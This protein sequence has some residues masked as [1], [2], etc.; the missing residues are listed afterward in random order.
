MEIVIVPDAEA[1]ARVVADRFERVVRGAGEQGATLGLATGSS[2]V[3][4]YAELIRRHR[5]EGLSFAAGR[6]FLLDEYVG[7]GPADAQSYHR[8]IR[9]HFTADVDIPDAAVL[10]PDGTA[11]DPSAEAAR[12]DAAIAA[13]GGIDLQVLGIGT[14]GHIAFNEPGSSLSSR[15]RHAALTR[16]T[17]EANAR[18]FADASEV[19]RTVLTQGLG[20]VRE[21]RRI[22]LTA[23]GERKAAAVA[24]MIEGAVSA[25]WPASC[26][27]LHPA[28]T[29]VV[30][31]AAASRLEL[32]EDYRAAQQVL[33]D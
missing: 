20:T 1:G 30:D 6:A 27:Q 19:P 33:A 13:A 18:F 24:A 11:A 12:Y 28:V 8:F 23:T 26:L 3:L 2:P 22:V 9:E 4:A 29:V 15:T 7:L 25:R 32:A 21:A 5:E 14:N 31:E 10:S 17:I 16:A